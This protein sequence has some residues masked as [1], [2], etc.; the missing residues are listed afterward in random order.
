MPHTRVI[1]LLGGSFNPAHEGHVHISLEAIKR[2]GLDEVWWLVSPQNPLKPSEGMVDFATRMA[3][4]ER[5]TRL[6]PAIRVSDFEQRHHTRYTADTLAQLRRCY[7]HY[8]FV[9]LMGADNLVSFHRWHCWQEIFSLA[10]IAVYD[11][12][13]YT[14]KAL[15]SKAASRYRH[16]RA[17][18]RALLEKPLPAWCFLH[19][20]RH[21]LS[22]TF[23]RKTLGH[24]AFFRHNKNA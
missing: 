23:L 8:R 17:H 22:A 10:A 21:Y 16:Y 15:K 1:G 11:R 5:I 4:A 7:P 2:V 12:A 20:K 9:W 13:P 18:P 6:C 3:T 14:Q 24:K 19:G